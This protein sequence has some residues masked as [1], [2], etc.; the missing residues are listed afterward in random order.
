MHTI[1]VLQ[2]S[3][4]KRKH[5]QWSSSCSTNFPI[6]RGKSRT[7][8]IIW[9]AL[10]RYTCT[11]KYMKVTIDCTLSKC[12]CMN[13]NNTWLFK[14][15]VWSCCWFS[16]GWIRLSVYF[17]ILIVMTTNS[18]IE[19]TKKQRVRFINQMVKQKIRWFDATPSNNVCMTSNGL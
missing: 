9:E 13:N 14:M 2:I 3:H 19:F 18:M 12:K 15:E 4:S 7:R 8:D 6:I 1:H 5:S 16:A 17:R 10:I 11:C